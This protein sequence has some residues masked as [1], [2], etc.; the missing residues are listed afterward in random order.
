MVADQVAYIG[1]F[2]AGRVLKWFKLYLVEYKANSLLTRNN[3]VKYMFL[4][5]EGFVNRLM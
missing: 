1:L 3:K 4:T 5:W 2:L